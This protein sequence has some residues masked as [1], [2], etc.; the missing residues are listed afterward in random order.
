MRVPVV[1]AQRIPLM[2]C[3][4]KR[5]RKLMERGEATPFW[6]SGVFCIRLN[7]EPSGRVMQ[8]VV[9]A[10][11]PGSK[12]EGYTVKSKA[13]DFLN[14]TADAVDW[15]GKKLEKR[16]MLRHN[17]RYR[18][19]PHRSP[20]RKNN[21]SNRIPAGTRAR[22]EWKFRL[23]NWLAKIYPIS[24]IIIEDIKART[25]PGNTLWNKSFSPLENGKQW[26]YTKL[27]ERWNLKLIQGYETADLREMLGLRKIKNKLSDVWEAHCVDTWAMC[28]NEVGGVPVPQ[29][30]DMMR[31]IPIQ[32]QR[33]CLHKINAKQGGVRTP[34][35]GTNKSGLKTGTLVYSERFGLCYTGGSDIQECVK[36]HHLETKKRLTRSA[37]VEHLI[38]KRPIGWRFYFLSIPANFS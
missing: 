24:K 3:S 36:I 15:V 30:R 25:K 13:H 17:R 2:P 38:L 21:R 4:P 9:A 26:F 10:V 19:T 12:R 29:H 20:R 8:D 32:R 6:S 5:A 11:D 16:K 34:Y 35:G 27:R 23:L 28:W 18:K 33:R 14:I 7:R 31:I 1:D 22:W 37:K